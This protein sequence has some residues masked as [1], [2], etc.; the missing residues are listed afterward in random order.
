MVVVALLSV[1][2]K[3]VFIIAKVDNNSGWTTG[4]T[5]IK[6]DKQGFIVFSVIF[7]PIFLGFAYL[8]VVKGGLFIPL[9]ILAILYGAIVYILNAFE[10]RILEDQLIY[11][12]P[13][14]DKRKIFY[15]EILDVSV[16]VGF[17]AK[18][19]DQR[20]GAFKL[21]IRPDDKSDND[22]ITINMKIFRKADISM[23]LN[24]IQKFSPS[25][26]FDDMAT[27]LEKLNYDALHKSM[28]ENI[29]ERTPS[30]IMF[31]VLTV[32]TLALARE[33]L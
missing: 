27:A 20:H 17:G 18:L 12:F 22:V 26:T 32:L 24:R 4:Q 21:V 15:R 16:Q 19:S 5:K 31:I 9:F 10:I 13:F 11:K 30:L 8:N 6:A 25:V 33:F 23:M 2:N 28:V 3:G 29:I 14:S 7:L 1:T